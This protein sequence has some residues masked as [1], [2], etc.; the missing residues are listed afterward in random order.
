MLRGKLTITT[1]LE[2]ILI[3]YPI[4]NSA[5]SKYSRVTFSLYII[6]NRPI[7]SIFPSGISHID[8]VKNIHTI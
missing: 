8:F 3:Y 2:V 5:K 4:V 6:H 1:T 7:L